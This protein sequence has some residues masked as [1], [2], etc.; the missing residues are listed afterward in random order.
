M[1]DI[2]EWLFNQESKSKPQKDYFHEESCW[3]SE[4]KTRHR[5]YIRWTEWAA[6]N[7]WTTA[8]ADEGNLWTSGV[9][10]LPL[11]VNPVSQTPVTRQTRQKE[12]HVREEGKEFDRQ[13]KDETGRWRW[14]TRP[15]KYVSDTCIPPCYPSWTLESTCNLTDRPSPPTQTPTG[16]SLKNKRSISHPMTKNHGF[17]DD[18]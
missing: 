13:F 12:H 7:E 8:S 9:I 16:S 11:T 6:K 10:R 15:F 1:K 18:D 14:K 17:C 3:L 2:K 4:S 5:I